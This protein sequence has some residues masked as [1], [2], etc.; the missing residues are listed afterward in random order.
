ME[1]KRATF[2]QVYNAQGELIF[3]KTGLDTLAEQKETIHPQSR[4][5]YFEYLA[6]ALVGK[7]LQYNVNLELDGNNYNLG[8]V[9]EFSRKIAYYIDTDDKCQELILKGQKIRVPIDKLWIALR[10]SLYKPM[11]EA[12]TLALRASAE[13]FKSGGESFE[14]NPATHK[15]NK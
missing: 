7:G 10:E 5:I 15:T 11:D 9:S 2:E 14:F 4:R 6:I 13:I 3:G 1:V 12:L 8:C